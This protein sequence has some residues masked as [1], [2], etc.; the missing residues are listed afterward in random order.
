ML[1]VWLWFGIVIYSF[2]N[3]RRFDPIRIMNY[4]ILK[5]LN[6]FFGSIGPNIKINTKTTLFELFKGDGIIHGVFFENGT[7]YPVK[8]IIQTDKVLFKKKYVSK[9]PSETIKNI[10][11]FIKHILCNHKKISHQWPNMLG[12]ANTALMNVANNTYAMFEQDIPYQINIDFEKK[13]ITTIG[14]IELSN[15]HKQFG[16]FRFSGHSKY[17]SIKQ[18]IHTID[19]NIFTR[20]VTYYKMNHNFTILKMFSKKMDYLPIVHD[21][22]ILQSGDVLVFDSPFKLWPFLEKKIYS[23]QELTNN[24][25]LKLRKDLPTNIHILGTESSCFTIDSG[26]Y[27]FHFGN[28][29][30]SDNNN[31]IKIYA[32]VYDEVNFNKLDIYGKY[33]E[34]VLFKNLSSHYIKKNSILETM[35]LDFPVSLPSPYNNLIVLRRII[36]NRIGGYVICRGLEIERVIDLPDE[37]SAYGEHIIKKIDGETYLIVFCLDGSLAVINIDQDNSVF[38]I[39]VFNEE[40]TLGFHSSFIDT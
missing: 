26:F 21:F 32:S 11:H 6:G 38:T 20:T 23:P 31:I 28:V 37:I 10:G 24:I 22:W 8:H 13:D 40:I 1:W 16:P 12:S 5:K 18:V 39:P 15:I 7:M 27:C 30:E 35:N 4:P 33:R 17:D 36:G 3:A 25:P 9:Y 2:M 14:K 34:I 29:I 19:Y